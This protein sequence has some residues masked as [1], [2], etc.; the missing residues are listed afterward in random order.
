MPSTP[1]VALDVINGNPPKTVYSMAREPSN[2]ALKL[3]NLNHWQYRPSGKLNL[4][5]V[6]RNMCLK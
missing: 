1:G 6:N 3:K 5:R 4:R 2:V